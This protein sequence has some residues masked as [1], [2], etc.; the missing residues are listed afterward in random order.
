[1]PPISLWSEP[2]RTDYQY[3]AQQ[4]NWLLSSKPC[5]TALVRNSVAIRPKILP[6]PNIEQNLCLVGHAA[7]GTNAG[8][9]KVMHCVYP[10]RYNGYNGALHLSWKGFFITT[11]QMTPKK[12]MEIREK[13]RFTCAAAKRRFRP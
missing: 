13:L 12:R 5:D 8:K 6:I 11:L 10:S 2:Y 7:K 1:M 9:L 4:M 3:E